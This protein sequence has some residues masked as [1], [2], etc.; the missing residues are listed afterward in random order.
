VSFRRVTASA[1]VVALAVA[2]C[3]HHDAPDATPTGNR[4]HG[5]RLTIY[6]SVPLIGPSA[7]SGRA[8]VDGATL[9]IDRVH[10][11]VG[12]YRITLKAVDDVPPG[13]LYWSGAATTLAAQTAAANATTIA[14][15]GDFN[16]GASAVSIPILNRLAIAQ[17]SPYSSAVGLTSDGIG[18]SPGEPQAYYPTALRTF[19]RVVPNDYVQAE[20]QVTLQQGLGCKATY[21]LSDG[22]YDG[23]SAKEAFL[24]VAQQ[25]HLQVV[26]QQSYVPKPSSYPAIGQTVAADGAD[27]LLI[28]AISGRD[29]AELVTEIAEENPSLRLFAT[30]GL[31]ETSFTDPADG[32]VPTKIDRRLY[33]T[34]PTGNPSAGGALRQDF[35]RTYEQR[36]GTPEPAAIDGY[37]AMRLTLGAIERATDQGRHPAERERVVHALFATRR[38]ASPLG[39]YSIERDGDT[40]LD[41]YDVYHVVDGA[42][43]Y[44][45]TVRG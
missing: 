28:S 32:G 41:T 16:S 22:E 31:A 1:A 45:E 8:V 9:A 30:A 40:S 6:V 4:I 23:D 17:I 42:L 39:R 10:A 27:C 20:A 35:T 43:K 36:Y 18:S 11:R 15:I 37:E 44:W 5:D 34:A 26:A 2:G 29:A 12:R 7:V 21:V 14:Y 25:R 24:E 13:G 38:H 19:A 3:G 33:V